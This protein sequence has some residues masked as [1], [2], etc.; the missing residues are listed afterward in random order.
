MVAEEVNGG[1]AS[2]SSDNGNGVTAMSKAFAASTKLSETN[3]MIWYAGI[4]TVLLGVTTD[5]YSKL[6]E[7][8]ER[9]QN[10]LNK[11]MEHLYVIIG[12]D[13]YKDAPTT[14]KNTDSWKLL[15][16]V[17]FTRP[18]IWPCYGNYL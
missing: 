8:L 16:K 11:T 5:P 17:L 3:Y 7:L 6:M 14:Y 9:I 10:D 1:E 4:L 15:D 18:S 13:L 12:A 2:S